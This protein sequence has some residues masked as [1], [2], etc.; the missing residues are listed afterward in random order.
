MG[1]HQKLLESCR[2]LK[3]YMLY[4]ECVRKYAAQPD[5]TLD[6]AVCRAV[7]ECIKQNILADFLK[8]NWRY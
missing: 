7:D 2:V 4:V 6:A 8:K 1:N 3:E 5:M